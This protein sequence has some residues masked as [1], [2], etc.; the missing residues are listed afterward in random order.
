MTAAPFVPKD[1]AAHPGAALQL[2]L[3]GP[4]HAGWGHV[5]LPRL[6]T[7]KEQWLLALLALRSPNAV[8]R[9]WLAGTLWPECEESRAFSNLRRSLSNLRAALGVDA[10]RIISPTPGSVALATAGMDVDAAAFDAALSRGDAASLEQAVALYRGPLLEG[11]LEEWAVPERLARETA[12]LGARERL[13]EKAA[14][15]GDHAGAVRHLAFVLATDPFRESAL[16]RLMQA[17]ADG[18]N[19]IAVTQTYRD[20]RRLLRAEMNAEP[21]AETQA[22]FQRLRAADKVSTS[23][24]SPCRLPHPL[25][26]LIGRENERRN[27]AAA[28][29]TARLVTL[30]GVGGVGKTRL[31]IAVAEDCAGEYPNGVWFAGLAALSDPALVPATVAAALE[32]REPGDPLEAL[33]RH[34]QDKSLLLVLDNCEHL[35]A[36]CAALADHLLTRC[37][38]LRLLATSRQPLGL[39]GETLWPVSPLSLD[40]DAGP[41]EAVRL[42]VERARQAGSVQRLDADARRTVSGICRKLDGIPLAIELAAARMRSLSVGEINVHLSDRFR[43]LTDGNRTALPRQ[44][45]LRALMDWSYHMLNEQEQ[46]LLQRLS[47][48][49]GGWTLDAVDAICGD[50][51]MEDWE[52]ADLLTSLVDKSLVIFESQGERMRYRLLETVRQYAEDRLAEGSRRADTR[53]RHAIYFLTWAEDVEPRLHGPDQPAWLDCMEEEHDNLRASLDWG[54]EQPP[55]DETGLRLAGP[56][57]VLAPAQPSRRRPRTAGVTVGSIRGVHRQ[58]ACR[59]APGGW[60]ARLLSAGF[61]AGPRS[62]RR[63][64]R[65]APCIGGRARRSLRISLRRLGRQTG[66]GLPG[67]AA[68][69]WLRV[70]PLPRR[71]GMPGCLVWLS[72][73]KRPDAGPKATT[74]ELTPCWCRAKACCGRSAT[75]GRW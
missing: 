17:L 75:L 46:I 55:D 38:G 72:G 44:Q 41:S 74:K 7:R 4:F 42:F 58:S 28:L 20:F 29:D 36:P 10:A 25:T 12:Y 57:L 3:F 40:D 30:T 68:P 56:I 60:A 70:W 53:R 31:S 14:G 50:E 67:G 65:P 48:F 59:R 23:A 51:G 18:E 26:S 5:P 19:R 37:T 24:K 66:G 39:L 62:S 73:W 52:V 64:G 45:T 15:R 69:C 32:V 11:C 35:P 2:Q 9:E 22:L 63:G 47:V 43:L 27:I 16:R 13:A 34:L 54:I 71:R 61:C 21:S 49:A 1:P 33:T 6:R 8:E